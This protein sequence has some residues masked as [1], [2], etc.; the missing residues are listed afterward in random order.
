MA[1]QVRWYTTAKCYRELKLAPTCALHMQ[2]GVAITP[3]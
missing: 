2:S 3:Q 1:K